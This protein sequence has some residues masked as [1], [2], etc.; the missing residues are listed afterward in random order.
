MAQPLNPLLSEEKLATLM[1]AAGSRVLIVWGSDERE[2]YWSRALGLMRQ[3]PE[4]TAVIRVAPPQGSQGPEPDDGP[5]KILDFATAV[6]A[7]PG[8]RL[9]FERTVAREDIAVCLHTGGTTSSPPV[10]QAEPWCD[11]V[12]R[13]GL[14]PDAGPDEEER[15]DHRLPA[16]SRR[17]RP[18]DFV[19]PARLRGGHIVIP[20]I[21][22]FRNRAV[23][24]NYWRMFEHFGATELSAV[25]TALSALADVPLDGADISTLRYC[26]TGAAPLTADL[27]ERVERTM[28]VHV[29]ECL[30]MTET[31]GITTVTPPPGVNG[32][33]GCV[34][35]VPPYAEIRIVAADPD[36]RATDLDLPVGR[37]GLILYRAPNLFSGY[38]GGDDSDG[39][40][41]GG[42]LDT[43]DMGWLDADERLNFG[44]RAKDLI[45]RSGHNI[46][47]RAIE[48]ALLAHPEVAP[49]PRWAPPDAYAGEVPAVFVTLV[50]GARATRE[51]LLAHAARTVDEPPPARP[52]RLTILEALPVTPGGQAL[53]AR[54]APP[55]HDRGPHRTTR[56]SHRRSGHRRHF[57]NH[58][59][60]TGRPG[61]ERRCRADRGDRRSSS[62]PAL[63][64]GGHRTGDHPTASRG[65]PCSKHPPVGKE[66]PPR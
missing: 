35:L 47:P 56:G 64:S 45:I 5:V 34:G 41:P 37:R 54:P 50:P 33:A 9:I 8:D 61:P 14:R 1:R 10:G 65:C 23:V 22:L 27:A 39:L 3:I 21:D 43:G 28:G 31:A 6:A 49:P 57:R 4:L 38:V 48:S 17:G 40:L 58:R 13:L 26:R 29:H 2:G 66:Q 32:P 15:I 20:T 44:G 36:G 16:V 62:S 12:H 60:G 7:E 51:E 30:G 19:A 55:R 52:K 59:S 11:R 24:S 46:D 53:Q 18:H 42:W 25:P 63:A